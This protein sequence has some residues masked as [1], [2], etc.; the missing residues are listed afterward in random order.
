MLGGLLG[1][2]VMPVLELGELPRAGTR[3]LAA[4]ATHVGGRSLAWIDDEL[5]DD[6]VQ[7]AE[8]RDAP[9]LLVRTAP[10]V[11]MTAAHVVRLEAFA[12]SQVEPR[13]GE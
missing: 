9:A 6:A 11:G 3:K 10:Y 4:V 13:D 7:R 5:Y 12:R 8:G 1:L 2:P